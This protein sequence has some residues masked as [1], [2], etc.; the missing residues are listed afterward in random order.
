MTLLP[1]VSQVIP[2]EDYTVYAYFSDGTVRLV[3]IKPYISQGG[4]F[5]QLEDERTFQERLTVLNDTVAWDIS[6]T[7][8][9]MTCI[10]I[11]PLVLYEASP[12]VAD[13]LEEVV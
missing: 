7:R 3:D 5:T 2:G 4:I 13:P 12:I 8:D 9:E 11:D 10:D 6:G 1:I